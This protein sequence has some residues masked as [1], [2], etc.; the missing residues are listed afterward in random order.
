MSAILARLHANLILR[1]ARAEVIAARLRA[2][3]P[4]RSECEAADAATL[5]ATAAEL[6]ATMRRAGDDVHIPPPNQLS[7]FSD[8][9]PNAR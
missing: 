6:A 3:D 8:G 7:L 5:R 9:G 1:A 4:N 2:A